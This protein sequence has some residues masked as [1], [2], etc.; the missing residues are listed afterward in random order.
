MENRTAFKKNC[1]TKRY[2]LKL[3]SLASVKAVNVGKLPYCLVN[4]SKCRLQASLAVLILYTTVE[5]TY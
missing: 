2:T 4:A 3:C 1:K 5:G